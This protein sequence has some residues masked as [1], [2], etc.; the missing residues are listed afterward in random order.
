MFLLV[1]AH[2]ALSAFAALA[3]E[4]GAA[5]MDLAHVASAPRHFGAEDAIGDAG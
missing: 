4:R 5:G 3:S 1:L 2:F